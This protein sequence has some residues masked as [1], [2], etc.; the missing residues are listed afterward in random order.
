MDDWRGADAAENLRQPG[1]MIRLWRMTRA[2]QSPV[3]SV[4]KC[5]H[6]QRIHSHFKYTGDVWRMWQGIQA[7]TNYRIS[8]PAC[9]S[10]VSLLKVL[11]HFCAWF[12]AQNGMAAM[13]T[14]FPNDKV[15]CEENSARSQPTEHSWSSAV[16]TSWQMPPQ[17]SSICLWAPL[18]F[19]RAS[20]PPPSSPCQR[21]LQCLASRITVPSH[22][23]II[24]N[25]FE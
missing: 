23:Q 12:E 10:E 6:A 17:I 19:Q 7:I 24:M 21:S 8:Q 15:F 1:P 16:Q 22:S 14:T 4:A 18:S 9:D 11:N 13:K 25:C 20:N 3:I 5:A 2:N